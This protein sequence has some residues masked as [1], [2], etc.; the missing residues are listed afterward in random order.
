MTRRTAT[1]TT[2][3]VLLAA[4]VC[5]AFLLP[6][7]Y[8][9]M[10]PGPTSDVLAAPDGTEVVDI[11]GARTYPTDG[12]LSLTTVSVTSADQEINL[13]EAVR[14]WFAEDDAVVPREAVY[15]PTQTEQEAEQESAAQMA[16]SQSIA[17]VAALRL[18]GDEVEELLQVTEVQ[19]RGPADGSLEAGDRIVAID[20]EEFDQAT[21]GLRLLRE[22]EPGDDVDVRVQRGEDE[23]TYTLTTEPSP[24]DDQVPIIGIGVGVDYDLPL[25]VAINIDENIGGPSAGAVF[26]LAIYDKLTEGSLTGG[27]S[28]AGT[29]TVD[30][31]GA[32]GPIGGIQQKILGAQ[33]QGASVFLVPARN[34]EEAAAAEVDDIVLVEVAQLS[35]AVESL[36]ALADDPDADVSTCG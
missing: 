18:R 12:S 31:E 4:L 2:A 11:D 36:E 30:A 9:T 32:V 25:D 34:C 23:R 24:D 29:G 33:E 35:D 3:A 13:V 6:V 27:M 15:A 21:E 22:R 8:V 1:T 5:V 26:A 17:A 14:A 28:V 19:A 16:S 20:G 7:P 10:R